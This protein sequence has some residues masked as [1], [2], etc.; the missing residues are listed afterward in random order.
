MQLSSTKTNLVIHFDVWLTF[1][2]Q[3][4]C[5]FSPTKCILVRQLYTSHLLKMSPKSC[6]THALTLSQVELHPA[7]DPLLGKKSS[8]GCAFA[9]SLMPATRIF[10]LR[11]A[12]QRRQMTNTLYK[13]GFNRHTH[14]S[15]NNAE[16]FQVGSNSAVPR[17]NHRDS[18]YKV[19]LRPPFL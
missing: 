19:S 13:Y 3:Q 18:R 9:K 7:I 15:I 4:N 6:K 16:P 17:D 8:S 10:F 11:S 5:I 2:I 14:A 12:T 1:F